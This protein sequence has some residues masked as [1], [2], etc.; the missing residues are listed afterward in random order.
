MWLYI[1]T[2]RK[3][4]YPVVSRLHQCARV[5]SQAERHLEQQIVIS[6]FFSETDMADTSRFGS[7]LGLDSQR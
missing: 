3:T 7:L 4:V 2:L 1:L 5:V 6:I